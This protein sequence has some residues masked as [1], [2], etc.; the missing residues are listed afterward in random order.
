MSSEF[1]TLG[2]INP[3][4]SNTPKIRDL[5]RITVITM[6]RNE[7]ASEERRTNKNPSWTFEAG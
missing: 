5:L 4:S 6:L 7:S 1:P 2:E 3:P